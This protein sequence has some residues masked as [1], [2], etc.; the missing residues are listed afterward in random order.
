MTVSSRLDSVPMVDGESSRE[1]LLK[2]VSLGLDTR[3]G[4]GGDFE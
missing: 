3:S 1:L 2:G 4:T